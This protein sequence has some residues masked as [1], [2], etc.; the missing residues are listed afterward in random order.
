M[1]KGQGARNKEEK[2]KR[3]IKKL[4]AHNI[5]GVKDCRRYIIYKRKSIGVETFFN[6][7]LLVIKEADL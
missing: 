5:P 3:G 7:P 2:K 6:T 4:R 1:Y